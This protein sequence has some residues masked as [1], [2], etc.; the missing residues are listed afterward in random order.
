MLGVFGAGL[1]GSTEG[2]QRALA[3]QTGWQE[4]AQKLGEEAP[5]QA[6]IDAL[7]RTALLNR[8]Q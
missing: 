7:R 8:E 1:A 6:I 4:A 5:T 2:T 3:G